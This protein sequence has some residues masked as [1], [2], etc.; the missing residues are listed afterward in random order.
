MDADAKKLI[1]HLLD[2]LQ[3]PL[4]KLG[5]SNLTLASIFVFAC[6][7]VLVFATEVVLRRYMVRRFL[8]RTHLEPSLQFAVGKIGGYLFIALGFY[9]A[10]KLVGID[11]SSLAVV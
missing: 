9:V 11:L 5:D 10:L 2:I 6:A 4:V 8:Q 1:G 7:M 3:Y